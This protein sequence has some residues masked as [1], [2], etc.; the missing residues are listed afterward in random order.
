MLFAVAVTEATPLLPIAAV[1][2]DSPAD[3]PLDGAVKV[4][5]PPATGSTAFLAVTV[6]PS[7]SANAAPVI[8]DCG[9]SPGTTV[10]VK[11]WLWKAPMS[12][13]GESRG[14]PRW[15]VVMPLT[16]VPAPMA[17]LPGSRAMVSVGPP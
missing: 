13:S 1:P 16:A 3:A 8:A 17:G 11:P 5:T 15:S 10:R 9:E 12:G 14:S 4:T 6:T 7:G 2:L